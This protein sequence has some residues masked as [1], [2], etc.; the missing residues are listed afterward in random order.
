MIKMQL[1]Y[2]TKK[3]FPIRKVTIMTQMNII[4]YLLSLLSWLCL[5][6]LFSETAYA[7][8]VKGSFTSPNT[9]QLYSKNTYKPH[10]ASQ[11]P[12]SVLF[13]KKN[14]YISAKKYFAERKRPLHHFLDIG[15]GATLI[16]SFYPFETTAFPFFVY[17]NYRRE[18]WG[19]VKIPVIFSFHYEPS[20]NLYPLNRIHTL[21][22][23]RYPTSH[24]L[25]LFHVDLMAG[26]SFPLKSSAKAE[27]LALELRLLFTHI[28]GPKAST[29]RFYFQ[30]GAKARLEKQ[31]RSGLVVQMGID[32]HL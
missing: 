29:H 6:L 24:D 10:L 9:V 19:Q 31:F 25:S 22:G 21:A 12:Y 7:K 3:S 27:K 5:W 8:S 20:F 13:A 26:V 15:I 30:W 18:K 1:Y 23:L 32:N 14:Y 28:I 16:E 2:F 4:R 11:N 17:L